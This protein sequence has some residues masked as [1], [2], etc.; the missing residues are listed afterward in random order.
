MKT[1]LRAWDDEMSEV[2]GFGGTYEEQCQRMVLTGLLW[3]DRHPTSDPR[4]FNYKNVYGLIEAGNL[5]ARNLLNAILDT[6]VLTASADRTT[7]RDQATSA[8]IH[9]VVNHCM[10]YKKHGWDAWR[11]KMCGRPAKEAQRASQ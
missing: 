3:I 7:A 2:S 11:A 1:S 10:Y 8:M 6:P 5:P 9:A 4:F